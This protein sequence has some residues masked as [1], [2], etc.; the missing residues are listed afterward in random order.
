MI[1]VVALTICRV[2]ALWT[3][4]PS[5]LRAGEWS[6]SAWSSMPCHFTWM[7]PCLPV[8]CLN[9]SIL[10]TVGPCANDSAGRMIM[11]ADSRQWF[12]LALAVVFFWLIYL[13]A[14]VITP[15]AIS[16][17]LA[18]LGD[19]F[20]DRLERVSIGKWRINRTLAVSV[21]FVLMTGRFGPPFSDCFSIV[22][23][24]GGAPRA[25]RSRVPGVVRGDRAS[26]AAG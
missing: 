11:T 19:P 16:A 1:T 24:T 21:V 23:G 3:V 8:L 22:A 2:S 10:K 14:P 25:E 18:Y 5:P 6:V 26:L 12:L 13:L 4:F 15:F 7:R 20:V 9:F 17:A